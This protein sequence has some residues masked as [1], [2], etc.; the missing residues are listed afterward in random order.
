MKKIIAALVLSITAST[1]V[2]AY[3]PQSNVY[4]SSAGSQYYNGQIS[5]EQYVDSLTGMGKQST[6]THSNGTWSTVQPYSN[7]S[8]H[9]K[10]SNGAWSTYSPN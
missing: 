8:A 4:G 9:I 1:T 10:H 7:G 3:Y 6:I 2:Q 5:T